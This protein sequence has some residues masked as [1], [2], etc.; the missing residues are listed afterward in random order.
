MSFNHKPLFLNILVIELTFLE[1]LNIMKLGNRQRKMT[2]LF[3]CQGILCHVAQIIISVNGYHSIR[4][5]ENF[6]LSIRYI[7]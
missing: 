5:Y 2:M 6:T 7:K 3:N 1:F 4:V